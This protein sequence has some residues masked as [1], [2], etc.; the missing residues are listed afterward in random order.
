MSY[1]RTSYD[2]GAYSEQVSQSTGTGKYRL[3]KAY[4]CKDKMNYKF[5]DV[6]NHD[7]VTPYRHV[8]RWVDTESELKN[9][10]RPLT[11]DPGQQFPYRQAPAPHEFSAVEQPGLGSRYTRLDYPTPNREQMIQVNR[12]YTTTLNPQELHRIH[13]NSYVGRNT[14]LDER[15]YFKMKIPVRKDQFN[16]L[17]KPNQ[18]SQYSYIDKWK[19]SNK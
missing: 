6:Q 19:N 4:V 1:T 7:T 9:L 15:D 16:S 14:T 18:S 11:R 5:G 10:S 13:S 3:D 8:S 2:E 12:F 17:P